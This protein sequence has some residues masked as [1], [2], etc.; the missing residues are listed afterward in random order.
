M[1]LE[2][3]LTIRGFAAFAAVVALIGTCIQ[4]EGCGTAE[5]ATSAAAIVKTQT[6]IATVDPCAVETGS[7][8]L[9]ATGFS[10][11][12]PS[13][14]ATYKLFPCAN[15]AFIFLPGLAG[16][17]DADTF[18]AGP[19]PAALIPATIATQEHPVNGFDNG[20]E[21]APM[22]IE[23]S[24]GSSTIQYLNHAAL[25]GWTS[26]GSKGV[27]LQVVTVFLD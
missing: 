17:S 3:K 24:S 20:L 23:I 8:T 25:S 22:S 5:A 1:K 13:G 26:S 6:T 16:T 7:F 27:G 21:V 9:T 18:T 4:L 19:L 14:T 2:T 10:G 12:A 11:T 15:L